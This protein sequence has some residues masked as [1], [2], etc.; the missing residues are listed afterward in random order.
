MNGSV[1]PGKLLRSAEVESVT[2]CSNGCEAEAVP[3]VASGQSSSKESDMAL[4]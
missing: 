2:T 4:C 1:S 3:L